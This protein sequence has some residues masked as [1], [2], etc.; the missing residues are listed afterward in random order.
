MCVFR[1]FLIFYFRLSTS[2]SSL[3][4]TNFSLPCF[5]LWLSISGSHFLF[6]TSPFL[7]LISHILFLTSCFIN[8]IS[9]FLLPVLNAL[10]SCHF[11]FLTSHFHHPTVKFRCFT[12]HFTLL[13][14]QCPPRILTSYF[15]LSD[16]FLLIIIFE[17]KSMNNSVSSWSIFMLFIDIYNPCWIQFTY[18]IIFI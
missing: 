5:L 10:P 11:L 16:F 2:D 6:L 15:R 12:S 7:L 13:N 18:Y 9:V 4:T 17:K 14:P 8:R 3:P 1:S